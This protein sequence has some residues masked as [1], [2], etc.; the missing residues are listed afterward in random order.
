MSPVF[1]AIFLAPELWC[2]LLRAILTFFLCHK[3][4]VASG[5]LREVRGIL[6]Q[7]ANGSTKGATSG[8][9]RVST[10]LQVELAG[11]VSANGLGRR[12]ETES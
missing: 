12:L 5:L 6:L 9:M 10:S 11:E 4:G 7:R 8:L 2:C 1:W 3:H